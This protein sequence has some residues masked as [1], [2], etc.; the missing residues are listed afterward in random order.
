MAETRQKDILTKLADAG[1]GAISRVAGSQT[2]TRLIETM[3]GMR[4]RMDDLQKK[5]RGLEELE[6]RVAKLEKHVADLGKPKTA[7]R[8]KST[9]A[10]KAST[11]KPAARKKPT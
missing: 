10:R 5:L 1:E 8:A 11:S 6:K 9:T 7:A 4:V 2:T 3:G